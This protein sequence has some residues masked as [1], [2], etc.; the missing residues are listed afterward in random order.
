MAQKAGEGELIARIE[1]LIDAKENL[2]ALDVTDPADAGPSF[3]DRM[4]SIHSQK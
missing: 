1:K 3:E 2:R 4:A